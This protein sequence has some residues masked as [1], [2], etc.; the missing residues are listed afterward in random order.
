VL[1][2]TSGSDSE[3]VVVAM[4][5]SNAS[6]V[7]GPSSQLIAVDES[8]LTTQ[9]KFLSTVAELTANSPLSGMSRS[10]RVLACHPPSLFVQTLAKRATDLGITIYFA[11]SEAAAESK[12]D[13]WIQFHENETQRRLRHKRPKNISLMFDFAAKSG[14]TGLSKRIAKYL[15]TA[16]I[17]RD[18]NDIFHETATSYGLQD[19]SNLSDVLGDA[20][21]VAEQQNHVHEVH[22]LSSSELLSSEVAPPIDAIID[23]RAVE[24]I[25]GRVRSKETDRL[26]VGNKTYILVS[27]AG[28]LGRS[29]AR[30]MVERGARYIVLSSRS[31]KIDQPWI[32]EL[33]MIGGEITALPMY[34]PNF[35]RLYSPLLTLL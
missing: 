19:R 9:P 33:A 2:K 21:K 11:S 12:G 13:H 31:P 14:P 26:L 4:T 35:E 27:L 20:V 10:M 28:D 25:P 8:Y 5:Q 30:F 23:W 15:P 1:G 34:V 7:R 22:L 6:R 17:T 16:C 32:D 3:T 18:I 24:F 29:I